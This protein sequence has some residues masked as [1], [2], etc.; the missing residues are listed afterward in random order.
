MEMASASLL[1]CWK[2]L[3]DSVIGTGCDFRKAVQRHETIDNDGSELIQVVC[4]EDEDRDEAL[5]E[6]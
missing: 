6:S 1:A 5:D 4:S 3:D 2:E